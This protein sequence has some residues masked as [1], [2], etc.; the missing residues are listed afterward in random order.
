MEGIYRLLL[1]TDHEILYLHLHIYVHIYQKLMRAAIATT[2]HVAPPSFGH[3]MKKT[4]FIRIVYMHV[5]VSGCEC[6]CL[7]CLCCES[8][9][10]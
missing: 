3:E 6:V 8:H 7:C 5:S 1:S 9:L 4:A 10:W 2:Y